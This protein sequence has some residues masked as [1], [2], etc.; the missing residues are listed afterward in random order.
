MNEV[1]RSFIIVF[2]FGVYCINCFSP[3][4]TFMVVCSLALSFVLLQSNL[5]NV[6]TEGTRQRGSYWAG[7][8][9]ALQQIKCIS[10]LLFIV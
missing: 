7:G 6:T 8:L 1:W 4:G 10:I 2:I 3:N 5:S 9:I